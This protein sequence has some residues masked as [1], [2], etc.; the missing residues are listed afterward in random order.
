ME[1][2]QEI[3]QDVRDAYII[4]I[5]TYQKWSQRLLRFGNVLRKSDHNDFRDGLETEEISLYFTEGS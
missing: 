5:G 3:V 2:G 1:R 4:A